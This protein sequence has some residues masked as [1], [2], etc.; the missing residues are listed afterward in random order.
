[1][2]NLQFAF[3]IDVNPAPL[4]LPPFDLHLLKTLVELVIYDGTKQQDAIALLS[5]GTSQLSGRTFHLLSYVPRMQCI[6]TS[7][8]FTHEAFLSGEVVIACF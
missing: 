4:Q 6:Y 2:I 5:T 8:D 1:M 3:K 7:R